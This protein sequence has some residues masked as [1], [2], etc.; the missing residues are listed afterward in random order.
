MNI[1]FFCC[2]SALLLTACFL[3]ACSN[4]DD[5]YPSVV[6]EL[7]EIRTG[8]DSV[9]T[10]L[11]TDDGHCY[12][13][14]PQGIRATS[15]DTIYRCLCMYLPETDGSEGTATVY[16]LQ[17]VFSALPRPR[18]NFQ[19][20][21]ADPVKIVSSWTSARYLNLRISILTDG[22]GTHEL[23]FCEDSITTSA[24]GRST[25]HLTLLH[26]RPE[27][28]AEAYTESSSV[29]LPIYYYEG[30]ADS[31]LLTVPTYNG[32]QTIEAAVAP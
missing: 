19:S 26:L 29:S 14:S 27:G 5:S 2:L 23:A 3:T 6:T 13:I 11:L 21:P 24:S 17:T 1:R 15:P 25:V 7:V 31:V 30:S 10:A 9:A 32:M 28:D 20:L 12:D 4:E 16:Q 18:E 8:S 22:Q